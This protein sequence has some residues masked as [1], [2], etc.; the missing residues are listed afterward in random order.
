MN[1]PLQ[2]TA[3]VLLALL[4]G[5]V[6]GQPSNSDSRDWPLPRN[7]KLLDELPEI[8]GVVSWRVLA[9]AKEVRVDGKYVA[10][11]SP[12]VIR[13]DQQEVS[14]QG[15]IMPIVAGERHQHFLLTMRPPHCPFC[16]AIGPAFIV[17]VKTKT[18][19]KHTLEPIVVSGRFNVLRDDPQG[20][21]YRMTGAELGSIK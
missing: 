15:Y 11:F 6:S 10:E 16:L 3:A 12:E 13:L 19:I 1:R 5:A 14:V 7:P 21:F 18:P 17:E 4:T 2:W 20:L 9:R 8:Q